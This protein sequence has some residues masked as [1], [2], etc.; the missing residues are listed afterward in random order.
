M[1]LVADTISWLV[2]PEDTCKAES[3]QE[4]PLRN[5]K[6]NV[7]DAK[8]DVCCLLRPWKMKLSAKLGFLHGQYY[9]YLVGDT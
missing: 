4:P 1:P 7:G 2:I 3:L 9:C 6:D 5:V 8:R